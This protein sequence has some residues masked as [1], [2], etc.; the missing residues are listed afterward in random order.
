M[1][2][3]A[4]GAIAEAIAAITVVVTLLLLLKQLRLSNSQAEQA[5][6]LARADSQR[7]ILKQVAE[8]ATLAIDNPQLQED[9]RSC[10]RQWESAPASAKWNFE[11]WASNYF[12]IME[13]AVYMHDQGLLS[14]ETYYAMEK[15]AVRIVLT[16]GGA[17]WW[18][19]KSEHIGAGVSDRIN[20][21]RD[22]SASELRPMMGFQSPA[23]TDDG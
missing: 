22:R 21:A 10:Y 12:Y 16:P 15:A 8:H 17:Q 23:S 6:D 18:S 7:D 2:W 20:S 1:N 9:I 4:L 13:Q 3:D 11:S 19:R 14:D 5:N